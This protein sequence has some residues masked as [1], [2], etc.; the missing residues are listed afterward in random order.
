VIRRG[1]LA[2]FIAAQCL[3]AAPWQKIEGCTIVKDG[4]RDGDSFLVRIA[5][6]T[7]R[8]FRLYFV[9]TPED[10]AD[11]RYP[12]RV[13]DQAKYFGV[14]QARALELGD[15][16]AAFTDKALAKPFTVWTCWQKAPGASSRQRFYGLL[17]TSQG[18]L[19][20]SLVKA[21]LARI[22]GKRI[23]LPDGTVSRDYLAKLGAM[24]AKAKVE[25][26]GAW[27]KVPKD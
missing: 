4:Y 10:S 13:A 22:Y 5:P 9:D 20:E 2:L 15:A 7:F 1:L 19:G 14:T 25:K 18:D 16:A 6:R 8:V 24:E 12:E 3:H 23:E 21:G 26:C 17:T 11:Q 27:T